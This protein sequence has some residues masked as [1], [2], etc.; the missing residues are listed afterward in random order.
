MRELAHQFDLQPLN[1]LAVPARA[2]YF[3]RADSLERLRELLD[4]ARREGLPLLVLGGGS[5]LVLREDFPGL[6]VHMQLGG[7]E[8]TGESDHHVTLRVGAG[9]NWHQLV[10]RTLALGYSGL[11]NLSLIPGSVGAAPIQN[12][13]A[14]GVELDQVFCELHALDRETGELLRFD[15]AD[16]AFGYRD[17]VFKQGLR[18]RLAITS[19]T[20]QLNKTP[21]LC[22]D[23]PALREA[24]AGQ[25]PGR[26]TPTAVSD[27]VCAI[28]RRKLPDPLDTPN[29][30]SFFKNPLVDADHYRHLKQSYPELVAH[31]VGERYKLAAGWLID[32]DGW[33]GFCDGAVAVHERQALVLTNAGRGGG[34]RVLAL[35]RRISDSVAERFQVELEIEPRLYP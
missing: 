24:L 32:R 34:D 31:P 14:Y 17:S 23:Y 15:R 22:L 7:F 1:T 19:V 27:A 33:R 9:E 25:D 29:V 6:V 11:E 3:G 13:G 5:N 4:F 20:L 12:I 16:C 35:A 10:R 18:D 26:L 2:A 21:S 30:G 28:R 8:L